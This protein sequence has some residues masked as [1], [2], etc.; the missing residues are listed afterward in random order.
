MVKAFAIKRRSP[1]ERWDYQA[2][3]RMPR[4]LVGPDPNISGRYRLSI[5]IEAR[6]DREDEQPSGSCT[7]EKT[8]RIM[9]ITKKDIDTVGFTEGCEG[10]RYIQAGMDDHREHSE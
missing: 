10:C 5:R 4:T 9:R 7:R 2:V 8:V 3:K 6:V 1:K